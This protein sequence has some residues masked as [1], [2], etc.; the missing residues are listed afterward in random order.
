M[1]VII[2]H[3]LQMAHSC[4]GKDYNKIVKCPENKVIVVRVN[5]LK[6]LLICHV[7]PVGCVT[8][9][10]SK[11]LTQILIDEKTLEETIINLLLNIWYAHL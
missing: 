10:A 8:N 2:P 4:A 11:V 6:S 3:F 1:S 7:Q 5:W 9:I